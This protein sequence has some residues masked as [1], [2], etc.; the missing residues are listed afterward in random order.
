M[1]NHPIENL[2][3]STMENIKDMI[4][5]NTVVGE[6]VTAYDGTVIIPISRVCFGFGCGG[7]EFESV[8]N[9]NS[10]QHPFGGG[11]GAGVTIK[12]VGFLVVK[13]DSIRLLSVDHH[14]TYDKIIDTVPQ[15]FDMVKDLFKNDSEGNE[16]TSQQQHQPPQPPQPPQQP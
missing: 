9:S 3:K 10:S 14:N 8:R 1:E 11:S 12:P 2:M 16:D 5:V 15:L 6:P 4:D 7:T 13:G